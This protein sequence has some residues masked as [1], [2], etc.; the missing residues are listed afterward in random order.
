MG[1]FLVAWRWRA[2]VLTITRTTKV[3]GKGLGKKART[4]KLFNYSFFMRYVAQVFRTINLGGQLI[5][6]FAMKSLWKAYSEEQ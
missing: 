5:A 6:I 3:L 2:R 4:Q 1:N